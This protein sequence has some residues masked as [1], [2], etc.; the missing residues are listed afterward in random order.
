MSCREVKAERSVSQTPATLNIHQPHGAMKQETSLLLRR[1]TTPRHLSEAAGRCF[2]DSMQETNKVSLALARCMP[3]ILGLIIIY[4]C[5]VVIHPLTI[6]YFLDPPRDDIER[7]LALG[8]A[9]PIVHFVLL[10]PVLLCWIRLL[11]VIFLDPGHTE[12]GPEPKPGVNEPQAGLEEFYDR[13]AFVCDANG[14]PIWCSY[15]NDYKHDRGHH[16]Q[17]TGRCTYKMDHFC[18][19]VGGVVG[20]RCVTSFSSSHVI[21]LTHPQILQ[22]LHPILVLHH[23]LDSILNRNFWMGGGSLQGQRSVLRHSWPRRFLLPLH[24]RHGPQQLE[25]DLQ[26]YDNDRIAK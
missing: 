6:N 2:C 19:W 23:G 16:N 22:V 4:A 15:C 17:D 11:L 14:L 7:R 21:L 25:Y 20:E 8:I 5:Y 12:L 13:D 9:V 24:H 18:P 26:E 3:V 10:I 1:T